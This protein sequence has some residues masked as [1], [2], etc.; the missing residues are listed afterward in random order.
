MKKLQL[1]IQPPDSSGGADTGGAL[2]KPTLVQAPQT[3]RAA[4][5]MK[6]EL[7]VDHKPLLDIIVQIGDNILLL[8]AHHRKGIQ[9]MTDHGGYVIPSVL[10]QTRQDIIEDA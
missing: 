3:S 9:L 1:S 6:L 10:C 5:G 8:P 4:S 7:P 2:S